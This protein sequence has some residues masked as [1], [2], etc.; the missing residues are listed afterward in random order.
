MVVLI[1]LFGMLV[2]LETPHI[3]LFTF[4]IFAPGKTMFIINVALLVT[5]SF[6]F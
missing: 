4:K 6:V 2:I 1:I 3:G 5:Q